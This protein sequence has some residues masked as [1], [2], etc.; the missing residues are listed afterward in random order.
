MLKSIRVVR[1][2]IVGSTVAP[3]AHESSWSGEEI[4]QNHRWHDCTGDLHLH[5]IFNVG[6]SSFE[7]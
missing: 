2:V 1:L 7:F 3:R 6:N 4:S 5:S